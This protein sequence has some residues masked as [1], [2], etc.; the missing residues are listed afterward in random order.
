[1]PFFIDLQ[2]EITVNTSLKVS[3]GGRLISFQTVIKPFRCVCFVMKIKSELINILAVL[4]KCSVI[5][6]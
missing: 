4:V 3:V 5:Y 2:K 6:V 1:M